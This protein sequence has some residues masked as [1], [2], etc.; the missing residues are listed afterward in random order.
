[1]SF[2]RLFSILTV[3]LLDLISEDIAENTK[4][5]SAHQKELL[6]LNLSITT[7]IEESKIRL[8]ALRLELANQANSSIKV[9]EILSRRGTYH[10][11]TTLLC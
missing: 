5:L 8:K 6:E 9:A 11:C 7:Y 1:M 3:R 2:F 10:I 4:N